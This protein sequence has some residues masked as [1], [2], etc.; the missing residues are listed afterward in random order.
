[1]LFV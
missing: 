1:M